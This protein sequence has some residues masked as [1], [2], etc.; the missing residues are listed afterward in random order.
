MT[1]KSAYFISFEGVEGVGKTTAIEL[2]AQLL[3]QRGIEY[4][5]NRE[6][7]GTPVAEALREIVLG[8]HDEP[9]TDTTEL[10]LMFAAR[11]QS[12]SQVIRPALERGAWVLC[13]RFTDATLAYQGFARGL[14]LSRINTLASWVHGELWPDAT[15]WLHAPVEVTKQRMDIRGRDRDRIEQQPTAFF[16]KAAAGYAQLAAEHPERYFPIE[17]SVSKDIVQ[18]RLALVLDTL[19]G[20]CT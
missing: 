18:E 20:R 13:D 10:L 2:F 16:D 17:T 11:A 9:L 3:E 7:G 5:R 6:P 8:Q 19:L 15:I 1:S 4:E 14:P 12:V